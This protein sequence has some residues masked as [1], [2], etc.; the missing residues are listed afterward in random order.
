M[1][2][3]APGVPMA[4]A[5]PMAAAVPAVVV[6]PGIVCHAARTWMPVPAPIPGVPPGLEY[7]AMV[8]TVNIYQEVEPLEFL[9]F[10]TAN[11]YRVTNALNQQLYYAVEQGSFGMH[12]CDEDRPFIIHMIDN[13]QRVS[14]VRQQFRRDCCS[15]DVFEV[16]D[17]FGRV[18]AM[19]RVP[20]TDMKKNCPVSGNV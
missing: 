2:A 20:D 13:A 3:T 19:I 12:F 10:E 4:P 8:D 16:F 11:R 15:D 9:G 5:V 17:A 1:A 6:Q 7:L 14:M 18:A